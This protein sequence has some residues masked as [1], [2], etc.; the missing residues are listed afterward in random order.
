LVVLL[1]QGCFPP[2]GIDP[3]YKKYLMLKSRIHPHDRVPCDRLKAGAVGMTTSDNSLFDFR[4]VRR[5]TFP[6][7]RINEA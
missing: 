4:Y 5:P 7:D 3:R 2:V 6:L 1:E